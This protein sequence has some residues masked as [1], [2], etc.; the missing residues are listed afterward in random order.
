MQHTSWLD[1][2]SGEE[3][4]RI[5]AWGNKPSEKGQY[6]MASP[7]VMSDLPQSMLEPILVEEAT[8]WGA[9]VRFSTEFVGLQQVEDG[10]TTTL[11]DRASG[12]EYEVHSKYVIGADGARSPVLNALGIPVTGKQINTAYNVHI[13]ADLTKYIAHRPGSLNWILNTE[14]PEWSAVGNFRMVRPWTE[15]VVSMHPANKDMSTFDPSLSLIH[16]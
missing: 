11:R 9:E 12:K 8:R 16:I 14:A 6:E 3:Y 4:G 2:L 5:W 15:F 7:C 13:K 10:V 1:K